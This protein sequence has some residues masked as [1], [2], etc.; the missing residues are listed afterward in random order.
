[1]TNLSRYCTIGTTDLTNYIS[2]DNPP[3]PIRP[4]RKVKGS[5]VIGSR[6]N[7][8]STEGYDM[9]GY[10]ID[11]RF[12][13]S[14]YAYYD[15]VMRLFHGVTDGTKFY[16]RSDRFV[17][18]TYGDCVP[19]QSRSTGPGQVLQLNARVWSETAELYADSGTS[20][21]PSSG[22]LPH[23]SSSITNNGSLDSA[24]YS[25]SFTASTAVTD[26]VLQLLD[27]SDALQ[28]YV[29]L[30][31]ALFNGEVL[32]VDRLGQ[33]TQDYTYGS[34]PTVGIVDE[35]LYSPEVAGDAKTS[36]APSVAGQAFTAVDCSGLT[37]ANGTLT[38]DIK[39]V[40]DTITECMVEITS[41]GGPD[42][43]EW[44]KDVYTSI[45]ED[46][47]YHTYEFALSDWST[48]SGELV[49][50][51]VDYVRVYAKSADKAQVW[52][53]NAKITVGGAEFTLNGSHPIN[54]GGLLV[55]FTPTNSGTDTAYMEVSTDA[56]VTWD[57]V[58]SEESS[59]WTDS[60]EMTVYVPQVV[61]YTDVMIRWRVDP[62]G[63][64]LTVADI[65]IHQER[66]VSSG[67]VPQI[68]VG[69]A[70]KINIAGTGS[71]TTSVVYRDRYYP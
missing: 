66:Y 65:S 8:I 1:M 41:S 37:K 50:S 17:H 22:A 12:A 16:P 26:L 18:C 4:S 63:S 35:L 36:G 33:I 67:L 44:H 27:G 39:Y 54:Q 56:G 30:T 6:R 49:V 9:F 11:C 62:G 45:I 61:G 59:A 29:N 34:D 13:P 14:Q 42:S 21:S 31:P 69:I 64:I 58:I 68:P 32:T 19:V 55:T 7:V 52:W 60:E 46:A 25:L 2:F 24:I 38:I 23:K 43:E 28:D 70:R 3:R 20:W 40:G 48:T 51:E 53:R 5:P 10:E 15:T 71:G 47:E 57:E